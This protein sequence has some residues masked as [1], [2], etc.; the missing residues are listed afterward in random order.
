VGAV[1]LKPAESQEA[2]TDD[3]AATT[4]APSMSNLPK[5]VVLTRCR[6]E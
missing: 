2:G 1:E 6:S 3:P 5:P 4:P